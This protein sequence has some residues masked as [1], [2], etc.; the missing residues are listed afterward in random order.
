MCMF[1]QSPEVTLCC[2]WGYKPSRNKHHFCGCTQLFIRY[3][4]FNT[5][6]VSVCIY[7]YIYLY[8]CLLLFVPKSTECYRDVNL[9]L[10]LL[11]LCLSVARLPACMLVFLFVSTAW[12]DRK[13]NIFLHLVCQLQEEIHAFKRPPIAMDTARR[14]SRL[15]QEDSADQWAAH[16][17]QDADRSPLATSSHRVRSASSRGA[18]SR[19]SA[20]SSHMQ[21]QVPSPTP[22][23]VGNSR[24]FEG[25]SLQGSGHGSREG[26]NSGRRDH[27]AWTALARESAA[28]TSLPPGRPAVQPH[29]S[30][31][32]HRTDMA[33]NA[34]STSSPGSGMDPRKHR[35][36]WSCRSRREWIWQGWKQ[37]IV[38]RFI[39]A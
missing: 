19:A 37:F 1:C 23:N 29:G 18:S 22:G 33:G 26:Y 14:E 15:L 2:W 36:Q 17:R 4:E 16:R 24:P 35:P 21:H 38:E 39:S 11:L 30:R 28:H 20:S 9:I 7:I 3:F 34:P 25:S 31:P 8:I 10:C 32:L 12:R 6:H 5:S 13:L 27:S